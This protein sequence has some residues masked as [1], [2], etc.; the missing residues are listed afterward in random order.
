MLSSK[1]LMQIRKH[2]QNCS[3]HYFCLSGLLN[4]LSNK[5]IQIK[6]F[7]YNNL[8]R[9]LYFLTNIGNYINSKT[10]L[11]FIH[12]NFIPELPLPYYIFLLLE[13]TTICMESSWAYYLNIRTKVA[14]FYCKKK[15]EFATVKQ[16]FQ[17]HL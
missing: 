16:Q 5:V 11:S 6:S 13:Y 3:W 9:Q 2:A 14:K 7:F 4:Y 8:L 12:H 17:Q 1:E 15:R 10:N